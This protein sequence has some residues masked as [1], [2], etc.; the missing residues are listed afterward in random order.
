MTLF[1]VRTVG[2]N[3]HYVIAKDFN[4]AK[5]KVVAYMA[6]PSKLITEDGSLNRGESDP[7]KYIEQITDELIR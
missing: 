5:N 7:I 4:D 1:A 2:Y 6:A 3:T